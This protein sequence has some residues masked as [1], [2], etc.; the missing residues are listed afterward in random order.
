MDCDVVK[1]LETLHVVTNINIFIYFFFHPEEFTFQ[2]RILLKWRCGKKNGGEK[3]EVKEDE[4]RVW[5]VYKLIYDIVQYI[6][7]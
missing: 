5:N 2:I 7:Y 4:D 1:W 3:S 6:L